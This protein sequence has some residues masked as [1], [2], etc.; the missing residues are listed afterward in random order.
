MFLHIVELLSTNYILFYIRV[1]RG[2]VLTGWGSMKTGGN[3]SAKLQ[4]TPLIVENQTLCNHK[5]DIKNNFAKQ[6]ELK[7]VLPEFIQ[8]NLICVASEVYLY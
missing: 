1:N 2:V 8:P 4:R 3:T 6:I 7:N 5:Y